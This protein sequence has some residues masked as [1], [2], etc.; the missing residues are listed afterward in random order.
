MSQSP[1]V[2]LKM[3]RAFS[4]LDGLRNENLRALARKTTVRELSQGRL[5]FKEGDSDKRTYFLVSGLVEFLAEGRIVGSVRGGTPEARHALAPIL[6]RRCTARVAS[7]RA[8]YLSLDSDM[9]DVLI[10]WDQ[11]G[12]YEVTE[13]HESVAGDDWMTVLLQ[14]RAFHKIPPANLQ[15]VFMRMQR[16]N[17]AAGDTVI[18]Q[19]EEGDYFYVIVSGRCAVSR[20]TPL[21]REG[22]RLAELGMG[23]TFGEESLIS[24]SVRNATVTMLTDG[25][26]MRLSKDDFNALLNEPMLHWVDHETAKDIVARGGRWLDVRLPSEFEHS[27]LEQSINVPLY[28]VRLKLKTLDPTIPYVAVCDNGRRSSAAAYILSER[29]FECYV[30]RDGIAAT[31]LADSLVTPRE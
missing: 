10:T 6:P 2:E 7:D 5:L 11:T 22:I 26:L 25:T 1:T 21:N 17:Y 27:H 14:S 28:F 15:A 24:G 3:L 30:L 8:E 29:G 12:T 4:P 18:R 16:V 20:E 13:L 9:L 31:D 19:G 23:E